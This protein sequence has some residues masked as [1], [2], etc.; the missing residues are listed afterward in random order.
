[1]FVTGNAGKLREVKAILLQGKP[2]EIISQALDSE[3]QPLLTPGKTVAHVSRLCNQSQNSK[4]QLRKLLGRS[5][6]GQLI[7]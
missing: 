2:I 6:D 5:A 4:D 1:M 7:W 3:W